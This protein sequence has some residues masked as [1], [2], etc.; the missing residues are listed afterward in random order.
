[1]STITALN[2]QG[3]SRPLEAGVVQDLAGR[4]QG[5]LLVPETQGYDQA[6]RV[7]NGMIDRRPALIARVR[8][9]A[10][11]VEVVDFARQQQLLTAVRGGG[12]NVTGNAV[13]DGGLVI[14]LSLMK[15]VQ[16][17]PTARIA[18]AQGGVTWGELDRETQ[19]HGLATP[20]GV[21]SMTGI[22]G[23]TLGGGL[24]WLRRKHGLS[25]DNLEAV[26]LVSAQ[27]RVHRVSGSEN[28]ELFW[29][30]KGGG[31][32][33]GV[34]TGFEYRLHPVGPQVMF[35]FVF[36]PFEAA[37]EGLRFYRDYAIT[38]PDE[39]SSFVIF[40][41]V[42]E[43]EEFPAASHG[44]PYMLFAACYAGP[45]EKGERVVRPLREFTRPIADLSGPMPYRQ[46]QSILDADYPPGELRYYW[47]SLY[48]AGLDDRAIDRLIELAALRPSP[49]STLDIWQMGGAVARIGE[50]EA[51]F[52][53]RQAPFLLGAESNWESQSDDQ[54]NIAWARRCC[55]E[56]EPFS[57]G[58]SYLNFEESG[59][60]FAKAAHQRHF[61]RLR[62]LKRVWDP[63]NLF[64]L[65]PNIRPEG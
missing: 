8:G 49:L 13:C 36:H 55:R 54:A 11:V 18:R 1:M 42:P 59:E 47:K 15:G 53:H 30:L 39:L 3:E 22:A 5:E 46:V 33:F 12:H 57:T 24:G 50:E 64:R 34:V 61:D 43:A 56:M 40:G 25:C 9:T 37:R 32:N 65:N 2:L 29:G 16:V 20:G 48:L 21:V 23:L 31:G 58:G 62:A 45:L 41:T 63:D 38:A 60:G 27:G 14:D 44:R 28:P 10:D 26:E 4:L 19:I 7:W 35:C 52:G 6:R 51:A 17:D